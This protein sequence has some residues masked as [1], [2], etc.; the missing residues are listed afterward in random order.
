MEEVLAIV[1]LIALALPHPQTLSCL[2]PQETSGLAPEIL[3]TSLDSLGACTGTELSFGSHCTPCTGSSL[4][5]VGVVTVVSWV[6]EGVLQKSQ[7]Y[8][9]QWLRLWSSGPVSP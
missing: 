2:G 3:A 7:S 4:I 8:S 6:L 9:D 1:V 5:T